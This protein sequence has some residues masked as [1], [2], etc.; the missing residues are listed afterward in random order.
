MEAWGQRT[1]A[2]PQCFGLWR[3]RGS[4]EE[5]YALLLPARLTSFVPAA[6]VASVDH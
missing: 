2:A 4:V 3:K 1:E 5:G 6:H